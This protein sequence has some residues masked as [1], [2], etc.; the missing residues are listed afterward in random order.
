MLTGARREGTEQEPERG[1]RGRT[2]TVSQRTEKQDVSIPKATSNS[3]Q[4]KDAQGSSGH[5]AD[6]LYTSCLRLRIA[7]AGRF[8]ITQRGQTGQN[9]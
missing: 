7:N 5:S 1:V 2:R 8:N 4:N 6:D 3:A 9:E